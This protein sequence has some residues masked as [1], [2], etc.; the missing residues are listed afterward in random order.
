MGKYLFLILIFCI[1]P[2][3]SYSQNVVDLVNALIGTAIK[4]EGGTVP[5]VGP[6]FAM[7]NF[8]PQTRENKMGSMAYVYDDEFI[9]GFLGSH[10]PTIWMGDYG[11]VSVMP[12]I[13]E[14]IRVLPEDRKM[15]FSHKDEKASPY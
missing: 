11:Y 10:Q 13:G 2:I 4:G 6:P 12:Q 14:E 8:L 3:Y 9:M 15:N 1:N 5:F 7:T